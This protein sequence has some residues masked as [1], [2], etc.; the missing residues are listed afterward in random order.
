M[1]KEIYGDLLDTK[2]GII[3]HQTNYL[4]IMGG[5]IALAIKEKLFTEEQYAQYKRKCS[6]SGSLI[7]GDVLFTPITPQL[8]VANC[9]CQNEYRDYDGSFTDYRA[10]AMCFKRV[11]SQAVIKDAPVLL[12]GYI[13]CGIAGGDWNK[14]KPLIE[15]AFTD[16][17]CT[18][19]Y[20]GV[21]S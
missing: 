4:G 2:E 21:K 18:I 11:K 6:M 19:V 13:G 3:C 5:G 20:K 12:P 17:D 1:I 9:F 8:T 7:M 16:I 15:K 10:M 14:V